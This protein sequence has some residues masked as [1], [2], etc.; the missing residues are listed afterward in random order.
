[1][2]DTICAKVREPFQDS[3]EAFFE[4]KQQGVCFT[5]R[6]NFFRFAA[7]CLDNLFVDF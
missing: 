1:M 4:L 3:Q 7:Q 5:V 6:N 2:I